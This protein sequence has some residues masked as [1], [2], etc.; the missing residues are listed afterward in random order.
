LTLLLAAALR[1]RQRPVTT[2]REGLIGAVA[3]A[4]LPIRRGEPGL[5]QVQGELWRAVAGDTEV[6]LGDRVVVESVDG[7]LLRV[8]PL[9]SEPSTGSDNASSAVDRRGAPGLGGGRREPRRAV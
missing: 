9:L 4:R 7:L 1:G 8:R 3:T 5:V 2:G 6:P